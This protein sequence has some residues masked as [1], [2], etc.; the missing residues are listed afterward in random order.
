MTYRMAVKISSIFR[1]YPD[2]IFYDYHEKD[3]V[4]VRPKKGKITT[5]SF[6]GDN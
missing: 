1:M 3:R 2:D 4:V 6:F 5:Y